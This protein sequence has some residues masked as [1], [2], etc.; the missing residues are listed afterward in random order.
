[1]N[2]NNGLEI[3]AYQGAIVGL[4]VVVWFGIKWVAKKVLDELKE[5]NSSLK[6]LSNN[7]LIHEGDIR[8]AKE[9]SMHHEKRL[10]DHTTRI[11]HVEHAHDICIN[12][13]KT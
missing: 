1:M 11:R 3:W 8:L 6:I 10:N 12:C 5:I 9:Q 4:L 13:K 2:A 7:S